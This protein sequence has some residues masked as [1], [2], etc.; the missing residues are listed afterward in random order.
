ML[1]SQLVRISWV[2]ALIVRISTIENVPSAA[3]ESRRTDTSV[4]SLALMESLESMIEVLKGGRALK[5]DARRHC[6]GNQTVAEAEVAS[7]SRAEALQ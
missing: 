2:D 5:K 1:G 4:M 6:L 3:S 7:S